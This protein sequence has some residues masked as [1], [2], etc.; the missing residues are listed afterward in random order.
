MGEPIS[1]IEKVSSREGYLRFET[2]RNFTGMGHEIFVRGEEIYGDQ[3][4]D[5]LAKELFENEQVEEMH[6]YAQTIT[7]K[8]A[9]GARG[10]GLKELI[11]GHYTYYRPG[12][13]VPTEESFS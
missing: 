9:D 6:V 3:P 12:V 11:E 8:L 5:R 7:I 2:N 13:E 1:V 4:V 10:S